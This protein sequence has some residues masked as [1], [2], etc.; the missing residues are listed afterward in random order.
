MRN[1]LRLLNTQRM[2][3]LRAQQWALELRKKEPKNEIRE[4]SM[5]SG[6]CLDEDKGISRGENSIPS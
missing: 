4:A 5:Q 1:R 3:R 6:E 2:A